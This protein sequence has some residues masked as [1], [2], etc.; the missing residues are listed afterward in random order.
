[1]KTNNP[2]HRQPQGEQ[3]TEH[4]VHGPDGRV[5]S[6]AVPSFTVDVARLFAP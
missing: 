2:R 3:Y 5:T 4:S 6:T 1:M